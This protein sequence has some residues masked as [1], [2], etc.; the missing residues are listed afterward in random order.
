MKDKFNLIKAVQKAHNII[1]SCE[2]LDHFK[3][4]E[5][6]IANLT[7][8]YKDEELTNKLNKLL[9]DKKKEINIF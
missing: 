9:N 5:N 7:E 3:V 4:A 8:L 6:Y 1:I 2:N